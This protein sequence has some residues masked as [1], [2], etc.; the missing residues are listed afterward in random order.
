M[1]IVTINV[2]SKEIL[3]NF[4]IQLLYGDT[5]NWQGFI[6]RSQSMIL[7]DSWQYYLKYNVQTIIASFIRNRN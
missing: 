3:R 6:Q 1:S 4:S 5:C 7:L 2:S